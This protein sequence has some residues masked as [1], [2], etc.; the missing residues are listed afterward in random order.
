M[1]QLEGKP[2]R[3][4]ELEQLKEFL[5]RMG[6]EYDPG[7]EYTLCVINEDNEIIGTGSVEENVLKCIAVSPDARGLGVSA[8][9]VSELVQYEFNQ[10]R[11]HIL[12]YTKPGNR[13]MFESLGFYTVL[14]TGDILFM[15]NRKDGFDRFC[16]QLAKE[17]PDRAMEPGRV[18]GSIV[19]NC[20]P[21]TLGHRYLVEQALERCDYVHLMILGDKRSYFGPEERFSMAKAG[22]GDLKRAIMHRVSDFVVSAATFPIYFLKEASQA[23]KANCRLDLELFGNRIA[24]ALNIT[25]R[26]V[27]TEPGCRIT[28]MYNEMMKEILPCHGVCVDEIPRITQMGGAVS[29]SA[30]R[31]LLKE[32]DLEGAKK[33]VPGTT[34]EYLDRKFPTA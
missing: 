3:G 15:E 4:K 28:R 21:F 16:W 9:I 12:L 22:V 18:I 27:G 33:L 20:N 25:K 2:F 7:V 23:G 29:A 30:V 17:T 32:G 5:G 14:L 11:P 10:G 31:R 24:P 34:W 8:A 13:D 6:L 19:A 26:F 1:I